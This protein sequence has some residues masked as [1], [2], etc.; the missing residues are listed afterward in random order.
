MQ[1][2]FDESLIV[3]T[4]Y[5]HCAFELIVRGLAKTRNEKLIIKTILR[6]QTPI[7]FE[8]E[9]SQNV[10]VFAWLKQFNQHN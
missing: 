7:C 9:K 1:N 2:N 6:H 10:Y 8:G 5:T 3:F 4:F